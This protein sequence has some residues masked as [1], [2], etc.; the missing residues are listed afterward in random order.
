MQA[1]T[2]LFFT[3]IKG[4]IR[5]I[6]S[7][8]VS[9]VI[10]FISI[11]FVV[12]LT[13]MIF[14]MKDEMAGAVTITDMYGL[15]MMYLG[16]MFFF[17][18]ILFLQKR[19]ALV[20]KVDAT[21]IFS[22]PF[23]R[24]AILNYVLVENVKGS[25]LYALFVVFYLCM[26][27]GYL[28]A[29]TVGFV[30]ITF[31]VSIILLF[32]MLGGLIY[33]YLLEITNPNAKKIKIGIIVSLVVLVL[34]LF[35]K[36]F[37]ACPNDIQLAVANFL[38]DSLFYYVPL[39]GY[40]KLCLVGFVSG[41]MGMFIGGLALDLIMAIVLWHLIIN[42]KGD[43]YEKV[44]EDAEW[45]DEVRRQAKLGK[46]KGDINKK[47]KEVKNV[48]FRPGAAA[49]A[50]KNI[51]E[52]RKTKNWLRMQEAF[53]M[54]FYLAI[55]F[56]IDMGYTFFQY[57]ILIILLMSANTDFI[58]QE[59]KHHYI[60]LIPDKPFKKI[61]YLIQPMI[62]KMV[63]MVLFGLTAGLIVFRPSLIEYLASIFS[64]PSLVPHTASLI[65]FIRKVYLP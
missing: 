64:I 52:L 65:S 1:L 19:T 47:I 20:Y 6:F 38:E 53:L 18:V 29:V 28:P 51:L 56:M 57:Y 26:M 21:Y 31:L 24:K 3:R 27:A 46:T 44:M 62:I 17:S 14:T 11:L 37:L 45:A 25:I 63:I 16:A 55:A 33:L 12:F 40:T 58:V 30:A 60:Y 59:L 48:T 39:F 9:G 15:I 50:S 4:A 54:L 35:A 61:M 13:F 8:A 36:N 2:Y 32:V 34:L 43:F 7:N 41:N 23:S 5:N 49:I 10:T 42:V 22:G